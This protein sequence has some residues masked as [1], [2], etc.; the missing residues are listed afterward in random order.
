VIAA[1]RQAIVVVE[2]AW[3]S[4]ALSPAGHAAELMRPVGVV[5][6]PV[7]SMASGGCHR[8]LRE[9]VATCVTDVEEVLELVG[10]LDHVVPEPDTPRGLLDGFGPQEARVLDALP[11]RG[12]AGVANPVRG[13][14]L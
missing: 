7:T 6:G 13:W 11:A 14:R 12:G 1:L 5:P 3:R 4:G 2:A 9:G 8:L 10:G